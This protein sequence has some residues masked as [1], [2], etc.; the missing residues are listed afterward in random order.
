MQVAP[1]GDAVTVYPVRAEPPSD[2]GAVHFT[3]TLWFPA[4]PI[5][6]VGASGTVR[7][8]T[9]A[10]GA[11]SALFPLTL[12][13]CTVKVYAVPLVKPVTVQVVVGYVME[14][15]SP[16]PPST[17]LALYLVI[18]KPPSVAGAVHDTET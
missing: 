16:A 15:V 6:P 12:V 11:D 14:Q 9:E 13:A 1:P 5:I 10:D 17:A 8:V 3:H 18:G 2:T 7:G 4:I